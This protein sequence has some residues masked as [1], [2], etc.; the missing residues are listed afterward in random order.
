MYY[1][2]SRVK[3]QLSEKR[4]ILTKRMVSDTWFCFWKEKDK[5]YVHIFKNYQPLVN[6]SG[7]YCFKGKQLSFYKI[8]NCT[9][10][11]YKTLSLSLY[12]KKWGGQ[13]KLPVF[14]CSRSLSFAPPFRTILHHRNQ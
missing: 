5:E 14:L 8:L 12:F 13:I 6:G 2:M 7:Q 11:I 9:F 4:S 3:K 10:K 1:G